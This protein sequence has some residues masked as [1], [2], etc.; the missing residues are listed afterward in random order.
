MLRCG[1]PPSAPRATG[2]LGVREG[3]VF[4]ARLEFWLSSGFSFGCVWHSP[5]RLDPQARQH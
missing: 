5:N 4:R 1:E 3:K 2:R